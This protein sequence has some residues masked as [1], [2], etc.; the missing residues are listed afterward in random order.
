MRRP[1]DADA[2]TDGLR[3]ERA[4]CATTPAHKFTR[5]YNIELFVLVFVYD[6]IHHISLIPRNLQYVCHNIEH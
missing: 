4:G 6:C 3:G 1:G 2:P 5:P